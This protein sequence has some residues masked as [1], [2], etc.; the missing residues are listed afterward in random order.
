MFQTLAVTLRFSPALPDM[1]WR[2]IQQRQVRIFGFIAYFAN[3]WRRKLRGNSFRNCCA[4]HRPGLGAVIGETPCFSVAPS[5][6]NHAGNCAET[7]VP[8]TGRYSDLSARAD[9]AT[10]SFLRL[11]S[12]RPGACMRPVARRS[13]WADTSG[14]V[15]PL[16]AQAACSFIVKT[17]GG[18]WCLSHRPRT[19]SPTRQPLAS[20]QPHSVTSRR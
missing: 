2:Y 3:L 6:R 12:L 19:T 15:H 10:S 20:Q 5:F 16:R 14:P 18:L 13:P 8:C 1:P 4:I 11:S 9:A 17:G 7:C